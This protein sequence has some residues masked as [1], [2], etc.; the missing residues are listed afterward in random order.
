MLN[1][2]LSK[3]ALD[4]FRSDQMKNWKKNFSVVSVDFKLL[5][6]R[7]YVENWKSR[8]QHLFLISSAFFSYTKDLLN[9]K[10]DGTVLFSRGTY[11]KNRNVTNIY[12]QH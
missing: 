2:R 7:N 5:Q 6:P 1:S 11:N 8:V 9:M 12:V 4:F 3:L 10:I